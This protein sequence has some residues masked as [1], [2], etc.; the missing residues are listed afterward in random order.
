[1]NWIGYCGFPVPSQFIRSFFL[2]V[3]KFLLVHLF[4]IPKF[5]SSSLLKHCNFLNHFL[6]HSHCFSFLIHNC[7]LN[8]SQPFPSSFLVSSKFQT[9]FDLENP[10]KR[11]ITFESINNKIYFNY[12]I[13]VMMLLLQLNGSGDQKVILVQQYKQFN[14]IWIVHLVKHLSKI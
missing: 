12:R 9:Y 6:I 14:L 3:S 13:V 7:F 5:F 2:I 10:P 1:M 11:I 8:S 4:S